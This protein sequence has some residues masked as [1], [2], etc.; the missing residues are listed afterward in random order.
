MNQVKVAVAQAGSIYGNTDATIEK[1]S[2]FTQDASAAGARLILFPEVFV[3]GYA[4]GEDFGSFV[5]GR[6]PRGRDAFRRYWEGAIDV[7]GA[8]VQRIG[9]VA[10]TNNIHLVT[11]VLERDGGTLYCTILFFSPEGVLLGK[12]RKLMPTGLERLVW[13]FGDGS[14]MPVF[15]T[16]VG[17]I[18][19]VICWENYMPLMRFHMYTQ[20]IQIY[21][22]PTADNRPDWAASMQHIA[23]EGRCFVLSSNQYTTVADFPDDHHRAQGTS[24]DPVMSS[25]GSCIVAPSGEF[26]VAPTSEGECIIYADL[27]LGEIARWKFDF[28]VVGHYSRPDIFRL[29]VDTAPRPVQCARIQEETPIDLFSDLGDSSTTFEKAVH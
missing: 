16:E 5:G 3:G 1:L 7:P 9:Q 12:H 29:N 26:L 19:A 4:R 24:S 11:G 18:G 13:G 21:L 2:D 20:G 17:K 15:D 22:A 25:G 14:T 6:T 23:K 10:R 28:D 27:D 8:E